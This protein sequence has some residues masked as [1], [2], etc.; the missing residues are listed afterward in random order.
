MD[1]QLYIVDYQSDQ[2]CYLMLGQIHGF[3]QKGGLN[4]K[5]AEELYK[6]A[7]DRRPEIVERI[8]VG[9]REHIIERCEEE[10]RK[11]NMYYK[12][13]LNKGNIIVKDMLLAKCVELAKEF[14]E[15]GYNVVIRNYKDADEYVQ[16]AITILWANESNDTYKD[17]D[18][19]EV[20]Y[21]TKH[22]NGTKGEM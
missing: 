9:V 3:I 16:F 2:R 13:Y 12:I 22:K 18:N 17:Y 7:L 15:L 14:E 4:I 19:V 10:S 11:G 5:T 1:I 20:L 21:D 6:I 8:L